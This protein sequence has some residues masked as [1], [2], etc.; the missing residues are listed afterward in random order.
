MSA[1]LSRRYGYAQ[2]FLGAGYDLQAFGAADLAYGIERLRS[3][4]NMASGPSL[5]AN[6]R[7]AEG[8]AIFYRSTSWNRNRL[9]TA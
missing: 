6:L 3:D 2:Q 7:D 1:S 9:P 4:A 5:A 8:S